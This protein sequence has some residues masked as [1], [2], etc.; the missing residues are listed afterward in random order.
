MLY[1]KLNS[2]K[3]ILYNIAKVIKIVIGIAIILKT[4]ILAKNKLINKLYL[5]IIL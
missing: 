2:I 3:F 1:I 4:I 5:N